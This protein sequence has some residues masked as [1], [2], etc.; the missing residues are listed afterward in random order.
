MRFRDFCVIF[1][2]SV[3]KIKR[4]KNSN[5]LYID[6]VELHQMKYKTGTR[7]SMIYSK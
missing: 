5:M 2:G 7:E 4:D 6:E 1:Y 3:T